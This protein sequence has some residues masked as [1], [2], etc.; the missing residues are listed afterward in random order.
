VSMDCFGA[1]QDILATQTSDQRS[2]FLADG[3]TGLHRLST[4]TP[5][6]AD[7]RWGHMCFWASLLVIDFENGVVL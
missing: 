4:K 5:P 1:P 6:S 2:H 7:C 3:L